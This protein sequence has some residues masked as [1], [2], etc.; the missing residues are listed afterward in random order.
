MLKFVDQHLLLQL[1]LLTLG[2]VARDG[3]DALRLPLVV[4]HQLRTHLER[5]AAAFVLR[6]QLHFVA[7]RFVA[8]ELTRQHGPVHFELVRRNEVRKRM[9]EQ[10][11]RLVS[12]QTDG[13]IDARQAHL[14]IECGDD[15]IGA[16]H[17]RPVPLLAQRQLPRRL[18][19][20]ECPVRN[21]LFEIALQRLQLAL[22]AV[23]FHEHT[24]LGAQ[25][26]RVDGCGHVVDGAACVAL[27]AVGIGV[28]DR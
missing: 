28:G 27:Q 25:E 8:F 1:R 20:F 12:E 19:Q 10:F 2:D 23:E 21:A 17:K 6:E 3:V 4:Q 16:F 13:G 15:I 26:L 11:G 24:D 9:A 5:E 7:G 14:E 22:L 18:L